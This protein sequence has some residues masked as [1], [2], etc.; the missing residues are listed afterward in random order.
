MKGQLLVY[1]FYTISEQCI[2]Y[3]EMR[4]LQNTQIKS[5]RLFDTV[6]ITS[7]N[8]KIYRWCNIVCRWRPLFAM[9]E[10]TEIVS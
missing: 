8:S 1:D 9:G 10:T 7:V 6:N 2:D 5:G 4:G 3:S